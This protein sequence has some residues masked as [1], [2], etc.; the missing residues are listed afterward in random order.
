MDF[1]D[2]LDSEF[3]S[4]LT[5]EF[6]DDA[7][8][9]ESFER[10]VHVRGIFDST[11]L[12]VDPKNGA[13]VASRKP[14]IT[15]YEGDVPFEI[16]QGAIVTVGAKAYK[17]RD[18]QP[19]GLESASLYLDPAKASDTLNVSTFSDDA[20]DP[21]ESTTVNAEANNA[22]DEIVDDESVI[23]GAWVRAESDTF[24]LDDLLIIS[25]EGLFPASETIDI[26]DPL[27]VA[28][29]I[30]PASDRQQVEPTYSGDFTYSGALDYGATPQ[31]GIDKA[32]TMTVTRLGVP[33]EEVVV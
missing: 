11:Y 5:G 13:T 31:A 24:A 14:R 17:V 20:P 1:R 22:D 28:A 32:M 23:E 30:I 6:A 18:I 12:E 16:V 19:D 27:E 21:A 4:M 15:V 26:S 3:R 25:G 33:T 29:E 8:V 7:L 2:S 9:R 10:V